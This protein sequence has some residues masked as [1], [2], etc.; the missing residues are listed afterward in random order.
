MNLTNQRVVILGGT[1]GCG[2]ASARMLAEAGA[3]VTIAGRS[4]EKLALARA[5]LP[6]SV[7]G[8]VMDATSWEQTHTFFRRIGF[9]DHL[10][11][12]LAGN[13]GAGE[14]RTLDFAMLHRV[15]EAKFWPQLLAAQTS[16]EFLRTDGSLTLV[17]A[18]TAHTAYAGAS[19]LA[20]VNGALEAL[21][22]TLALELQPLRVNA[23][24][25]GTIATPW[26]D[27]LPAEARETVF[28]QTAALTPV[29]RVGR[30]EDVAQVIALLINNTFLTGTIIDC[31]GGARMRSSW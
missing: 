4:P 29:K 21:I 3:I 8:E 5:G 10:V 16:L 27:D 24:A 23:V 15:F 25:P 14:F 11:L 1:S 22:P 26:W 13:E 12:T 17:S 9:F 19:G 30:P 31:D 2:L 7:F 28:R 6:S 20:A 18:V